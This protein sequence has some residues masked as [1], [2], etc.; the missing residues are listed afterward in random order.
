V[1]A[2][3]N[4]LREEINATLDPHERLQTIVVAKEPWT[5]ENGM[6]TPTMKLKRGAIEDSVAKHVRSW[7][8][9]G[10]GVVWVT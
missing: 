7:Y 10:E 8:E 6:L 1:T 5:V 3:L 4:A 2:A 9:R